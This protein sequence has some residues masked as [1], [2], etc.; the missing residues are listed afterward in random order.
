MM[1]KYKQSEE[2]ILQLGKNLVAELQLDR[3]V[4]TLGRWMA[5]YVAELI[6]SAENADDTESGKGLKKET[7]DAILDLWARKEHLPKGQ[8]L[9]SAKDLA[10]LLKVF[11][12]RSNSALFFF[13]RF[14]R[15]NDNNTWEGF[16]WDYKQKSEEIY[17][18]VVDLHLL[19]SNVRDA[20]LTLQEHEDFL[21]EEDSE[22]LL[23]FQSLTKG[24]DPGSAT[25]IEETLNSIEELMEQQA[26]AFKD[27]KEKILNK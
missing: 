11:K 24:H 25:D 8:P 19:D 9:V 26:K 5:H 27:L 16:I 7:F 21:T 3:S 4:D 23:A 13:D 12:A 6:D 14:R 15:N 22:L 1:E 10:E 18:L 17:R 20:F 2:K